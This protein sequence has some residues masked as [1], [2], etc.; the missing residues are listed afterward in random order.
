MQFDF[1]YKEPDDCCFAHRTGVH[2]WRLKSTEQ[3]GSAKD[4]ARMKWLQSTQLVLVVLMEW[5]SILAMFGIMCHHI[6]IVID[7]HSPVCIIQSMTELNSFSHP[8][9]SIPPVP[10]SE[11]DDTRPTSCFRPNSSEYIQMAV[12][13]CRAI[14]GDFASCQLCLQYWPKKFEFSPRVRSAKLFPASI[15]C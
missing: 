10:C 3:L 12:E 11:C 1:T 8:L 7:Y 13:P 15:R 6:S 9:S 14:A 5:I 2:V 4:S